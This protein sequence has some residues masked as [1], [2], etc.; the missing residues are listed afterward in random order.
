ME[1]A[2]KLEPFQPAKHELL[3]PQI[4][5][6]VTDTLESQK[7]E[8]QDGVSLSVDVAPLQDGVSSSVDVAPLQDGVSSSVDVVALWSLSELEMAVD[9]LIKLYDT[10]DMPDY[11]VVGTDTSFEKDTDISLN[12][13]NN[14]S[15]QSNMD[16]LFSHV[17]KTAEMSQRD[18]CDSGPSGLHLPNEER[19]R[20]AEETKELHQ[21]TQGVK[22]GSSKH[23]GNQTVCTVNVGENLDATLIEE[24][25]ATPQAKNQSHES[26]RTVV[27][28]LATLTS[29]VDE[30]KGVIQQEQSHK[31]HG[32]VANSPAALTSTVGMDKDTVQQQQPQTSEAK[33]IPNK[34]NNPK[35]SRFLIQL[36]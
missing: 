30:E 9:N 35:L 27:S 32:L 1:T 15:F 28:D 14:D 23:S 36:N 19:M 5:C 6:S 10:V 33:I 3:E 17:K 11:S 8:H 7:A 29:S 24:Q 12:N 2:V 26:Y 25:T 13:D 22:P 21:S 31:S 16:D 34:Q 20:N 4:D 18:L